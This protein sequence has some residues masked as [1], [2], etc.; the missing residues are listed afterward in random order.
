M[1][2]AKDKIQ[3]A[4]L[5]LLM[6]EPLHSL[7]IKRIT[8]KAQIHRS[9]FYVYYINKEMLYEEMMDDLLFELSLLIQPLG[10]QTLE[11]IKRDYFEEHQPLGAAVRFLE[12]IQ[13]KQSFYRVF[14][15]DI[16]FQQNFAQIVSDGVYESNILPRIYTQHLGY[17]AIGLVI[18]WLRDMSVYTIEEVALY[19]TRIVIQAMLDFQQLKSR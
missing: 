17:G 12:H 15:H 19:L 4:F 14:I 2:F 7:T 8:E 3:N 10:E 9:T 11:D 5:E 13:E 16:R 6:N 1:E 18:E